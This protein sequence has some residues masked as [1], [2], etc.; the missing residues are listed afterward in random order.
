MKGMI[1]AAGMGTRLR[2][3]TDT[4]PKCLIEVGGKPMLHRVIENMRDAG[5]ESVVVNVHHHA[6]LVKDYIATRDFGIEVAVSDESARLLDTGGGI[7]RA[8]PLLAGADTV[9]VHNADVWTD[10]PLAEMADVHRRSG[11]DVTLLTRDKASGRALMWSGDGRMAGWADLCTGATRPDGLDTTQLH[12]AGFGGVHVMKWSVI[13]RIADYAPS[14]VFS[15]TPFY[16]DCCGS[17]DIRRFGVG[18]WR[19]IDIGRPESLAQARAQTV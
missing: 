19:W 3:I 18:Q 4:C 17:L 6:G 9:M 11:A 16:A 2:P 12:A 8:A 5:V 7:V 14:D 13:E 10:V 15:I 1:F